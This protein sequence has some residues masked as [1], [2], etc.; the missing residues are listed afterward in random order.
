[1]AVFLSASTGDE[2]GWE[3]S[4]LFLPGEGAQDAEVVQAR[5]DSHGLG[6]RFDPGSIQATEDAPVFQ[7]P[8]VLLDLDASPRHEDLIPGFAQ[9]GDFGA[10]G[11]FES[12]QQLHSWQLRIEL[13]DAAVASVETNAAG[14]GPQRWRALA[15]LHFTL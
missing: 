11:T 9:G 15:S 13:V 2:K 10:G 7:V 6:M 12:A 1:M 4:R 3:R 14:F 8:D 5:H